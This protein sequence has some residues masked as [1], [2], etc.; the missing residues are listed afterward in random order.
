MK[1][2]SEEQLTAMAKGKV[3]GKADMSLASLD[4]MKRYGLISLV[5]TPVIN[6]NIGRILDIG[7]LKDMPKLL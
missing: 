3:H 7:K 4:Y 5:D 2:L 6:Q 1:Y